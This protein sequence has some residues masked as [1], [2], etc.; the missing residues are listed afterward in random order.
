MWQRS[1]RERSETPVTFSPAL[2]VHLWLQEMAQSS[3]DVEQK[4]SE[5]S[6]LNERTNERTFAHK[7]QK[8]ENIFVRTEWEPLR[9]HAP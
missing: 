9:V 3:A 6:A 8:H 2:P 5:I 1:I 4:L 7:H